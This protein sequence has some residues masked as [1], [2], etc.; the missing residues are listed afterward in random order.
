MTFAGLPA[1]SDLTRAKA[2]RL[3][4]LLADLDSVIVAFSGG[5][6][7]AYL[8]YVAHAT[9]GAR[10]CAVTADSP[11]YP[12][13]H[14]EMA[15]AVA[16]QCQLHH[17]IIR[18]NE[19]ARPEYRANLAD[20]CYHCKH[21]L[22]SHLVA[23]ADARGFRAVVDGSNAD[24]RLD[25][26]PGRQAAREFGVRSPLDEVDLTKAEI[27][28]LSRSAELPVWDEPASACLS[29]RI[30]YRHEVTDEKLRVIED[31]ENAVH[32]LGFRQCRVRHHDEIAR[33]EVDPAD[34]ARVLEPAVRARLVDA[35]K[36]L[37]FRHVALDLQGYRTGSLNEGLT[38]RPL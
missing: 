12:R 33:V 2:A 20:R 32:A 27:R 5:V 8:A 15:L 17:E 30:P 38:L 26:R 10:S 11:S 18:T 4:G 13:R 22:Y 1:A 25:Y 29:S 19:M 31:A 36:A 9:L 28:Q 6:D 7:S 21:E 37:G 34:M 3:A 14:R 23:L 35:L 16:R 24:D